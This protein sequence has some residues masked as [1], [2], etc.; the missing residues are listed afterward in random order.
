MALFMLPSAVVAV[1]HPIFFVVLLIPVLL[2]PT[3]HP[4][5]LLSALLS[6]PPSPLS[7]L[8]LLLLLLLPLK[9]LL[10]LRR[11]KSCR[12]FS[13]SALR[14]GDQQPG[15]PL[16]PVRFLFCFGEQPNG[17]LDVRNVRCLVFAFVLAIV[18]LSLATTDRPLAAT[19]SASAAPILVA[20]VRVATSS[21]RRRGPG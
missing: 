9:L 21:F 5:Q 12:S 17:L 2:P 3:S 20:A 15:L 13:E 4:W 8:L 6:R 18:V 19:C 14:V 16:R 11:R 1:V 10:L 7:L